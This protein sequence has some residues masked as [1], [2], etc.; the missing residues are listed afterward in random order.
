MRSA[1]DQPLVGA[2]RN[3]PEGAAH[4]RRRPH[5]SCPSVI[6]GSISRIAEA[7]WL[8]RADSLHCRATFRQNAP[9]SLK[10]QNLRVRRIVPI[11]CVSKNGTVSLGWSLCVAENGRLGWGKENILL[12]DY[13]ADVVNARGH[14]RATRSSGL[15]IRQSR[16]LRAC[17]NSSDLFHPNNTRWSESRWNTSVE[18]ARNTAA[19]SGFRT[20]WGAAV[21]ARSEN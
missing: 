20:V 18:Q 19:D 7:H 8:E 6:L 15:F 14:V 16:C 12:A 17:S 13:G 10:S 9:R 11:L 21:A 2:C 4:K 5:S 3:G 1:P